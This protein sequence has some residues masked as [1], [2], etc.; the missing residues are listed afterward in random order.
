MQMHA[1]P[2]VRHA[3]GGHVVGARGRTGRRR[4]AGPGRRRPGRHTRQQ[5]RLPSQPRRQPSREAHVRDGRAG[6]DTEMLV[7]LRCMAACWRRRPARCLL[8]PP[9]VPDQTSSA[10]AGQ[11]ARPGS[12]V[13]ASAS[14]QCQSRCPRQR[15][16][17]GLN[18][19]L[20]QPS[21]PLARAQSS[22]PEAELAAAGPQRARSPKRKGRSN[23]LALPRPSRRVPDATHA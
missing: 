11:A 7:A 14:A 19:R 8:R 10:A 5:T 4:R 2:G 23:T 9:L 12:A 6:V 16:Q 1:R 18:L 22:L 20:P 21:R 17:Q 3:A 15:Q 13:R